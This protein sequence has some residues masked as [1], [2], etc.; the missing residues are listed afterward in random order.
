MTEL[1]AISRTAYRS[2][3]ERPAFAAFFRSATPIDLIAGLG[4]GSRPTARPAAR[5]GPLRE[6]RAAR[7]RPR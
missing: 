2:L 4:L 1:T 7:S 6:A 3:V 5:A